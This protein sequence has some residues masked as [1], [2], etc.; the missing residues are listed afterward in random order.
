[1]KIKLRV[2]TAYPFINEPTDKYAAIPE[3]DPY[4]FILWFLGECR[5]GG[6]FKHFDYMAKLS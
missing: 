1:M 2:P 4:L 6:D 3:S 5:T